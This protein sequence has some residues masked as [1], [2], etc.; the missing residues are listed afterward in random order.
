MAHRH[1]SLLDKICI[2]VDQMLRTLTHHAKTTGEHNPA[3]NIPEVELSQNDKKHIARLMRVNHAGEVAAQALYHGQAVVTRS[4]Q[5]KAKLHHAALEEGNHLA[6]CKER[7]D[8]L[9]SHTSYLNPLWYVGSF[10][11]GMSAGIVGDKWSLG[12]I[13]ETERQVIKHLD[14]HLT[15]MPAQD[16]KSKTILEK[17]S[18]DEAQHRDDALH[19]GGAELPSII[20]V[21]MSLT[22]KVMVKTA[23]WV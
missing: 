15:L 17:M 2:S 12:F 4:P 8:E 10:C 9:N 22:S 18:Q 16:Q 3:R 23:L 1:Y 19:L 13:S 6:W 21:M 7:L 11:I 5:L 14:H 20:K